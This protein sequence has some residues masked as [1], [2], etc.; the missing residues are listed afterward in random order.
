MNFW[1]S[2]SS[3]SLSSLLLMVRRMDRNA[4]FFSSFNAALISNAALGSDAIGAA[5]V[6]MRSAAATNAASER[7]LFVDGF[8]KTSTI[9]ALLA[10]MAF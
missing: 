7:F 1:S 5:V 3:W 10:S 2:G 9:D 6:A 4:D 8:A